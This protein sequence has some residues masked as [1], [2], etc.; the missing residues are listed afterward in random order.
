[1]VKDLNLVISGRTSY[2]ILC[3]V[4]GEI[5]KSRVIL[6]CLPS[7]NWQALGYTGI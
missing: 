2:L 5:E 7:V 6:R 4:E 3:E 1:M